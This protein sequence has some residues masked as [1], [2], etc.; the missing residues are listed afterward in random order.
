MDTNELR[1]TA[2]EKGTDDDVSRMLAEAAKVIDNLRSQIKLR[3]VKKTNGELERIEKEFPCYSCE[4]SPDLF[5]EL[6]QLTTAQYNR[7]LDIIEPDM[8]INP[9]AGCTLLFYLDD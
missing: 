1:K 4:Q 2:A 8:E 7:L 9:T 3:T 5:I 6:D